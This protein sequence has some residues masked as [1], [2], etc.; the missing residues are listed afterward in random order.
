MCR[1]KKIIGAIL[2]FTVLC[3]LCVL[4]AGAGYDG[5]S[6][7]VIGANLSEEQVANVYSMF[8]IERGEVEELTVTNEEEREYLEGIVSESAIGTR[9]I[10]CVLIKMLPENEGLSLE[11]T[12]INWCTDEIYQNALITAGI[13]DAEVI[14]AAPF[15]VSGTAALT[16]IYKAYEDVTG[17]ELS[18]D[19][20]TTAVEEL[21][22]TSDL[23][24]EI[25]SADAALIVNELKSIL[26]ETANMTDEE[27]R[28]EIRNI[29]ANLEIT[30]T[31]DQ[32]D[33]L[34][35]LVRQ[36]EKLD[37]DELISK[38]QSLQDAVKRM[39]DSGFFDKIL[40]FFRSI[41]DFFANLFN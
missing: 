38:V 32:I 37:T 4:P 23:A 14:V 30:L 12:N 39:S 9:S 8:G 22:I 18:E 41:G 21:V 33:Q 15:E 29:A 2:A 40:S 10:S 5:E 3:S 35:S 1:Y 25:G 28:E 36:L 7:A 34:V 16:G 17:E 31:E 13:Y 19:A 24:D 11:T 26:D 27:L 20:K 6:R